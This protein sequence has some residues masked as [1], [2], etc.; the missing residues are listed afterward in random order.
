MTY[1]SIREYGEA[2][3]K[4]YLS[5]SKKE[6][7]K[8][9]TEFCTVTKYHRK[10]AVRLLCH[11]P[12]KTRCRGRE[13]QYGLPVSYALRRL[14]EVSDHLCSK[15][16]APFIPELVDSLERHGELSLDPEVKEQVLRVSA[17]TIDRLLGPYRRRGLR[18]P[19]S[20]YSSPS[21]IKAHIP[22]RTFSEWKDVHPG[23]LQADLVLHC[24]ES[25][26]GFYVTTLT[27]V[28][29]ATGWHVCVPVWG[30]G[31]ERVGGGVHEVR[32]R[33]P[34]T[35]REI[36][37][38]NG[39]EF[40]NDALYPYCQRH[41][42]GFTRGRPYKKNDQAY[43]E[44]KNWSIVRRLV[45]YDRYTTK[46]AYEQMERLYLLVDRYANFF[47]P[48]GK[49]VHKER[50]GA[51]VTKHYD[52][53]RT[54]YKRLLETGLLQE[55]ERLSLEREYQSLNPVHL[56]SQI[57]AAL[58]KLWKLAQ[59]EEPAKPDNTKSLGNTLSDAIS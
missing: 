36:H 58:D 47:Q 37:T 41:G 8:L 38:D 53:A 43:V 55:A 33:L 39:S 26:E 51:K 42:I 56:K 21:S 18:H 19:R 35:L 14:W 40:I 45:G 13:R 29:V 30:K 17:S 28:D 57:D 25:T 52:L 44:Q 20:S 34:F 22:V 32:S 54:P 6:K 23:S 12:S 4:R 7:G 16:L 9:L 1:A 2:M 27:A 24:G 3:R 49:L 10:A 5:A 11:T 59:Q 46:A 48:I 15:R 50:V 31:K